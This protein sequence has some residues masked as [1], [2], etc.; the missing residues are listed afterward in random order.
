MKQTLANTNCWYYIAPTISGLVYFA[1]ALPKKLIKALAPNTIPAL[2][3]MLL[4]SRMTGKL[5]SIVSEKAI[6]PTT[7]TSYSTVQE[8]RF[9]LICCN[10]ATADSVSFLDGD[11]SILVKSGSTLFMHRGEDGKVLGMVVAPS[12]RPLMSSS[13]IVSAIT[14]SKACDA[15]S[16]STNCEV[17]LN[18]IL[19]QQL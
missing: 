8:S 14:T 3:R 12:D 2:A 10:N 5:A 18:D 4:T 13:E 17:R 16:V 19:T 9:L 11:K 15:R 7:D 6:D 1:K